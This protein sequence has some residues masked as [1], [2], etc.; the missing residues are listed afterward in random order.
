MLP[1]GE[2]EDDAFPS[3]RGR[4]CFYFPLRA[5]PTLNM[6]PDVESPLWDTSVQPLTLCR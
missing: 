3:H 1:T 2:E 6:S 5:K 4:R